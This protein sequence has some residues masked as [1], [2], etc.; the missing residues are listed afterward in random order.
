MDNEMINDIHVWRHEAHE[1]QLELGAVSEQ[2]DEWRERAEQ[3]ES[4]LAASVERER[5]LLAGLDARIA[6]L[7]EY[8]I[9][10]PVDSPMRAACTNGILE[11]KWVRAAIAATQEEKHE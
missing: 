9:G 4:A 3:A 7:Y 10:W 6:Q 2:R 5:Q 11:L 8:R 1:A